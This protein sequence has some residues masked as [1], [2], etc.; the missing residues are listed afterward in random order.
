M[1]YQFFLNIFTL[2]LKIILWG[3]IAFAVIP[4]AIFVLLVNIFPDF[5]SE[6]GFLFWIL[7]A[8]LNIPAYYFLWNSILWT[9]TTITA[10]GEKTQVPENL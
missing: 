5:T 6:S 4:L 1:V 10:L 7:F 8:S 3:V 9:I 2:F